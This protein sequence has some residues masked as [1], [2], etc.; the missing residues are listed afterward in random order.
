M[1]SGDDINGVRVTRKRKPPRPP[2]SD[3][4]LQEFVDRFYWANGP[5]CAGCDHWQAINAGA[6]L[7]FAGPPVGAAE[8]AA[9]LGITGMTLNSGAGQ[10]MTPRE[11]HCGAFKDEFDWSTLPP[12]YL[13]KIGAYAKVIAGP[14]DTES[15][16]G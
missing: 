7:C 11:Y 14:S 13:R 8:R 10:V 6:G 15:K 5:C 2:Q 12:W 3:P 1:F 4:V 9:P 16:D